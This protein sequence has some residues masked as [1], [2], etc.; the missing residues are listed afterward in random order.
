MKESF[1]LGTNKMRCLSNQI[2]E[3]HHVTTLWLPGGKTEK[4]LEGFAVP[5]GTEQ[6]CPRSVRC[7]PYW[8]HLSYSQTEPW[9]YKHVSSSPQVYEEEGAASLPQQGEL[10]NHKSGTICRNTQLLTRKANSWTQISPLLYHLL[11]TI[12]DRF[13]NQLEIFCWQREAIQFKSP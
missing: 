10:K 3:R 12:P 1:P 7:H 11:W 8:W 6:R 9:A 13:L 2:H 4:A 5:Q